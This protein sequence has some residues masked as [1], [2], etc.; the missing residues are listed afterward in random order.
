MWRYRKSSSYW[1]KKKRISDDK[2]FSRKK[3]IEKKRI[4][5]KKIRSNIFLLKLTIFL[6]VALWFFYNEKVFFII[7]L[8]WVAIL[9]IF[10]LLFKVRKRELNTYRNISYLQ[11][12]DPFKFEEYIT[13]L[14]NK[15]WFKLETTI[16]EWDDW[17]D[18]IWK[19]EKWN[20][21]IIQTKRYSDK[22]VVWSPDIRNFIWSMNFYKVKKWIFLTT[23]YFS[24]PAYN[25]V[26]EVKWELEIILINKDKLKELLIKGY[27]K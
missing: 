12:M 26:E 24:K 11:K 3:D 15:I 25:T 18:S 8:I 22:N 17:A 19:D 27:K 23:W 13:V 20:K 21:I 4:V 10:F 9:S 14:F 7:A 1:L 6:F 5:Q 2:K 16:A